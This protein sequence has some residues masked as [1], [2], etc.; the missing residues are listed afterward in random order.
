MAGI[1][2]N[3][4]DHIDDILSFYTKRLGMSVWLD[5]GGCVI[6]RSDNLLLGFCRAETPE[7]GGTITFFYRTI[8]EVDRMYDELKDRATDQPRKNEKYHIYQFFA[9]DP[10]DR[11][12]EFQCFLHPVDFDFSSL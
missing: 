5:Q 10:E 11:Q 2:F 6:L 9:R 8:E 12:L 3:R 7:T 4:T 1:V